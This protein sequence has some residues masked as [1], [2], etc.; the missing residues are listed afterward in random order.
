MQLCA[1]TCN[2][3]IGLKARD[4]TAC[5]EASGSRTQK[6]PSP[7]RAK[8]DAGSSRR[9][10][11]A[12][13]ASG[14]NSW[15]VP[16]GAALVGLASPQAVTSRAFSPKTI[17]SGLKGGAAP[18]ARGSRLRRSGRKAGGRSSGALAIVRR[19]STKRPRL[20]RC[21]RAWVGKQ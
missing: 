21:C 19:G 7:V 5:G 12:L 16:P 10:V 9:M 4:V 14:G 3:L 6:I 11:P 2:L 13:Q 20:R 1:M 17:P 8:P 18:P 15:N